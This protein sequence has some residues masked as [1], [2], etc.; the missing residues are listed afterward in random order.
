MSLSLRREHLKR[1]KDLAWLLMKYGRSDLTGQMG[2]D[3]VIR[4]HEKPPAE[5]S[6]KAEELPRDLEMLGPTYVKLGQFLSTR[7]DLL[8]PQYMDALARLQDNLEQLPYEQVE[9]IITS[10]LGM[11]TSRAFVEFREAPIAAAS[12]AQVHLAK[13]SD[14]RLVAVKVQRPHIR[15]QIIKD[16][17]AF[18]DVAEFLDK[19]TATAKRYMLQATLAEFRKAILRELDFRQEA[20][21][22]TILRNNLGNYRHI[23]V[24]SPIEEYTTSRVLTMDYIKGEKITNLTPLQR[25]DID[26]PKLAEELFKAY[27]QQILIDG[28][29]HADPHP[30]NVVLTADRRIALLDL[31]MVAR[32]SEDLQ[33]KLLR[34]LLAISEGRSGEAVEYALELGEKVEGFNEREFGRHVNE[35]VT[36]YQGATIKEIEVGRVVLE[37]FKIAGDNGVRFPTDLAML[38]KSLLNLD[39]IGRSLDPTFDPNAAIREHASE[40]LRRK[41][42]KSISVANLFELL[43]DSKEFIQFLPKRVNKVMGALANSELKISVNAIDEKYLMTGFQKVANR[44]TVGMILAAIIIGAALMMRVETQFKILGYP[45]IA[46]I[47]FFLAAI[48]GLILAIMITFHDERMTKK[49]DK[50]SI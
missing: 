9:E 44:L 20:Q 21:N 7:S 12:L 40:L 29:F 22:L 19:H 16:L 47:F 48:G 35:L 15:D 2:L 39:N 32:V 30:G 5:A 42:R 41:I 37:I 33:R 46:M 11:R 4:D 18:E 17:D 50:P 26:A 28:F 25:L 1:Y 49:D 6:P 23:V 36:R 10:E 45:G 31:G 13:L 8:P 27:L 14:G 3:K 34:L 24:P 43:M 38:G